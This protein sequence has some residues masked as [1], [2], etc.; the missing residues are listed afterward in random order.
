MDN[1]PSLQELVWFKTPWTG[2]RYWNFMVF[3]WYLNGNMT[4]WEFSHVFRHQI[5][6]GVASGTD[7]R[8]MFH[9]LQ[10]TRIQG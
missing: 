8:K 7:A 2:G 1:C 3:L 4:K 6:A 5:L 10:K 9:C